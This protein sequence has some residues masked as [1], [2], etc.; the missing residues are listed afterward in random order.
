M[1]T[2]G[3]IPAALFLIVI[4]EFV[5]C[6]GWSVFVLFATG[7][8]VAHSA[9]G[10]RRFAAGARLFDGRFFDAAGGRLFDAGEHAPFAAACTLA[11]LISGTAT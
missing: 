8:W 9:V 11:R 5:C 7:V 10:A 3:H 2:G 4:S 1:G 6:L